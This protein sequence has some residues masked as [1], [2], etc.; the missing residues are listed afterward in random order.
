MKLRRRI[1]TR[2]VLAVIAAMSVVLTGA[3]AFVYWRVSYA[4]DRQLN[5]DLTA[6]SELVATAVHQGSALPSGPGETVQVYSPSGQLVES[7]PDSPPP[8]VSVD[9]VRTATSRPRVIDIG[10]FVPAVKVAFR[11]SLMSVRSPHGS[12]VVAAGISRQKHDE[13]LRELLL[14]L[15]LSDIATIVAAGFVGYGVARAALDPVERY[16]LAA[17]AASGSANTRLPVDSDRDDELTRLGHTFNSLL[18]EIQDS[19][20]RERRFLSDA[21]HE[22]RTPL[23]VLAAELEWAQHRPRSSQQMSEVMSSLG[24]QVHGLIDLSNA[25]LDLEELRA[26]NIHAQP[27]SLRSLALPELDG[28]VL[29][30]VLPDVEVTCDRRWVEVA[31]AN[32]VR[33]SEKYGAGTITV[34]AAMSKSKVTFVVGDEG[35]GITQEFAERAFERFSRDEPS[36]TSP[37]HG[38][39]LAMVKAVAQAHGG[40]AWVDKRGRVKFSVATTQS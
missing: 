5:Q 15:F 19:Q 38:L 32:L 20:A 27:I 16:R 31:L 35:H 33:N 30:N 21:A 1:G 8:L 28:R 39:G 17:K 26:I 12:V 29:V 36:R 18:A 9:D 2:L 24:S 7:S 13:A 37:G 25:L 22:L 40:S 14:Q 10:T 11:V 23:A 34:N 4:L 6:Y 3:G